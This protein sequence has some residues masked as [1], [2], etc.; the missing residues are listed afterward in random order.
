[1]ESATAAREER[2]AGKDAAES[3]LST[4][5]AITVAL[6]ATFLGICQIKADNIVQAMSRA[7]ADMIDNWSYYQA[8]NIR[9]EVAN[10]TLTELKLMAISAPA[11]TQA[12][13]ETSIASY[14]KLASD[15]A[16]KKELVKAKA[17]DN[18][19]TYNALNFRDDQ[20]DLCEALLALAISMLA[21]TALTHKRWLYFAALIP[22]TLGILVG[23]S[24]FLGWSL[25]SQLLS[26]L[27]S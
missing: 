8:R 27:L 26:A 19:R 20:F 4:W 24:G 1:M 18:E 23:L 22:T 14:Q 7:Q 17:E 6:I 5:V 16:T 21:L 15:Q 10:A 12:Q 2:E 25:H 3:R 13:F 11:G 9:E